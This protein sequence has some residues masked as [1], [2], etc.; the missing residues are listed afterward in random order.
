VDDSGI[1]GAESS[2]VFRQKPQKK[3]G[4]GGLLSLFGCCMST[5][6]KSEAKLEKKSDKPQKKPPQKKPPQ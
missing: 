5:K 3:S 6:S 4:G 1:A 2:M